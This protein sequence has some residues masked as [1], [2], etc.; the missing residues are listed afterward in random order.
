[1]EPLSLTEAKK[2]LNIS[3]ADEDA[4]VTS[5]IKQAR[6]YC[7]DIQ[8]RKYLT[9]TWEMVL[10]DFPIGELE[11][12]DCSP[13]QSITSVKY[14]D[15]DGVESTFAA[16]NYILDNDS[17]VNRLVLKDNISWPTVTLQVVNGVRIRFVAGHEQ[18]SDVDETIKWAMVLQ[19]KL[20]YD[21]YRPEERI[22]LEKAR[23]SLLGLRRVIPV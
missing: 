11:F 21:D 4:L 16:T 8:N 22:R 18:A 14:T 9:Q 20:L 19:M 10:D 12:H 3:G 17:F 15:K 13:V 6:E 23:N 5:L 7:E 2:R 1:M